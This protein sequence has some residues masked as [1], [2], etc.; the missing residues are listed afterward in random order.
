MRKSILKL[1][2]R[3]QIFYLEHDDPIQKY[4]EFLS[5]EA[6]KN[7]RA[8]GQLAATKDQLSNID[9]EYGSSDE[10]VDA[11]DLFEEDGWDDSDE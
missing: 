11:W 2:R 5:K 1:K 8:V 10:E 3:K 4:L 7:K 9:D 6:L